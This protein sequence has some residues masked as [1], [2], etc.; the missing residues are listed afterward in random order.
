VQSACRDANEAV[1][2]GLISYLIAEIP[3]VQVGCRG[4]LKTRAGRK[5]QVIVFIEI[6]TSAK[7][8]AGAVLAIDRVSSLMEYLAAK[9]Q[10]VGNFP[11]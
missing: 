9:R 8:E 3:R 6:I 1:C 10:F 11:L 2:F 4:I 7:I 5:Q